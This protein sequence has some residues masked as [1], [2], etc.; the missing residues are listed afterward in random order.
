MALDRAQITHAA[1]ELLD[2]EGLGGLSTRRLAAKLGVQS[3]TLY[4]HVRGKDE[5]LD[6]VAEAI[7]ADAFSIDETAPW[8]DQ[9]AAGLRQFR[10]ILTKHRDAAE[11]LRQ[12]PPTGPH[13]LRHIEL[14]IA[15][16]LR[17]G[18]T[19]DDA[20]G[21]SRLL[22][23]HV[24]DSVPTRPKQPWH[25]DL[26]GYPHLRTVAPAFARLDDAAVFELGCEVILDGLTYRQKTGKSE[27]DFPV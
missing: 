23:A 20:A 21:I 2:E 18:F 4:W 9:L 26:A 24:L 25:V 15:I 8:R 6:L 22:T 27:S 3:P 5:L 17:A 19:E 14:T 12:R 16:L 11:L 10:A 7:C 13:R 1:V